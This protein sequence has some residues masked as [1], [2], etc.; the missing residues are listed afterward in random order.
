MKRE[1]DHPL[2][3]HLMIHA[4]EASPRPERASGAAERLRALQPG[5]AHMVHMPS[6]IDVR[7]GRWREAALANERA[8]EADRAYR[9]I[10]PE[11]GFYHLYMLHNHHMLAFAAM[12]RGERARA[13][14]AIDAMFAGVDPA[15]AR[16]NAAIADGVFALPLEARLRFGRWEEV[17]A[18]AEPPEWF[19]IA[20]ALRQAARGVAL[21][22]LGRLDEAREAQSAF[23]TARRKVPDKAVVGNSPAATVLD[24]AERLMAGEILY[25]NGAEE[26]AF[27]MLRAAVQAEDSLRYDEPP[28]WIMPVRHALGAALLKSGRAVEAEA[29]YRADLAKH[30]ENG[31]SLFGL[32]RA[33]DRQG[34]SAEAD[35]VQ[36]RFE[37]AW[38]DADLRLNSSCLCIPEP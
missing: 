32:A 18:A 14:G 13:L 35:A 5:L 31:W 20:R 23:Q 9:A 11:Q 22:A 19:P 33:L 30:P 34:K 36:A 6:H 15:W 1:P 21:A 17:L 37:A 8:I 16:E 25:R 26:S 27:T 38:A 28:D 29:V 2:A 4:V 10:R 24:V 12:M 3:L 7:L